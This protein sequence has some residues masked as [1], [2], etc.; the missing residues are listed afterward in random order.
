MDVSIIRQ[1]S[2]G[3]DGRRH[4][5]LSDTMIPHEGDGIAVRFE[6]T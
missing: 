6:F 5:G 3:Q 4:N 1:G 2:E